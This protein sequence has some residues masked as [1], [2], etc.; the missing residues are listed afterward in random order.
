MWDFKKSP[1]YKGPA[2]WDEAE[3]LA[4]IQMT[5]ELITN[6]APDLRRIDILVR[7]ELLRLLQ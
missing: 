5:I 6:A 2:S 7:I 1:K 3:P 4:G